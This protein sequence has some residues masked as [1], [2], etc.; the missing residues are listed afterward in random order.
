M[1]AY[2]VQMGPPTRQET[3]SPEAAEAREAADSADLWIGWLDGLRDSI[4][5]AAEKRS[6]KYG[7]DILRKAADS[8]VK[9]AAILRQ[10]R[11]GRERQEAETKALGARLDR[12]AAAIESVTR[13]N[14]ALTARLAA[15]E[16]ETAKAIARLAK[17][18]ARER[19]LRRLLDSQRS[20]PHGQKVASELA[21]RFA[22][23]TLEAQS[24]A[25]AMS[26]T[27]AA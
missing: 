26:K 12:M 22:E 16:S 24:K 13:E 11:E 25:A 4:T 10:Q 7:A 9:V 14:A 8:D 15:Q 19:A 18:L 5:E 17:E 23:K 2:A 20:R 1:T 21:R 27:E 3:D 6:R